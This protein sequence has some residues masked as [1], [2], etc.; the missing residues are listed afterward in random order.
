[1][2]PIAC[3]YDPA[4]STGSFHSY[5]APDQWNS[6]GDITITADPEDNTTVY[7]TGIEAI[8]GTNEDR[9]PLV[10]HINPT[11]F[12][13]IADHTLIAT[14][15]P[16]GDTNIAYEGTGTFNSCNGSYTM[17][18]HITVAEGSYGTFPF[19]FTKN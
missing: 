12:E 10:M 15:T 17:S 7:V 18:F 6:E 8:E 4:I 1:V 2:Y 19:T 11:T 9:G 16:W 14:T 13:V 5:S 3:G